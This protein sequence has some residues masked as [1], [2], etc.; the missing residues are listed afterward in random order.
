MPYQLDLKVLKTIHVVCQAGSV[1]RAAAVLGISPAAVSYLVNKARRA[2]GTPLFIR[3]RNGMEPDLQALELSARYESISQEMAQNES[4]PGETRPISVSTYSIAELLLSIAIMNSNQVYPELIFHRQQYNE[5]ERLIKLRNREIDLDIGTRLPADRSIHQLRL[6]IGHA[7][8][9][10][11]KNHSTIKDK[12]TLS[13]WE[14]NRHAVWKRGMHFINDDFDRMHRFEELSQTKNIAFTSSSSLNVF[15]LCALSDALVLCPEKIGHKLSSIMPVKW[16]PAPEELDMQY[17]SYIHYHRT[18]SGNEN[19]KELVILFKQ[20]LG[21]D[22][23]EA[24]LD[25]E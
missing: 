19:L 10:M 2:T 24:I 9:L 3:T 12:V 13:D 20:A 22:A 4:T 5:D 21:L 1:T 7:G 14:N 23:D 15:S 16:L 8:V 17:I 18:M 11:S 6:L 25:Q